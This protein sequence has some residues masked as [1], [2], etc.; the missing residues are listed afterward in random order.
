MSCCPVGARAPVVVRAQ[1]GART[2]AKKMASTSLAMAVR[3]GWSSRGAAVAALAAA[4][5]PT[6]AAV[7]SVAASGM[8][9]R[10]TAFCHRGYSSNVFAQK[11]S[12]HLNVLKAV[13]EPSSEGVEVV[14]E[15]PIKLLTSDESEDL[16]KIRHTAAHICAMATQKLFPE[17]QCTIGPW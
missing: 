6:A 3:R 4:G 12:R 14:E 1:A 15:V 13:A 7:P 11:D 5:R 17:A 2:G 16:L 8:A 9:S 10:S